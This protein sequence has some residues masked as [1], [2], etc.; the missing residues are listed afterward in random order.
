MWRK[1]ER[2]MDDRESRGKERT[3]KR[4]SERIEKERERE[5]CG[6]WRVVMRGGMVER[7]EGKRGQ[8]RGGA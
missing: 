6:V 4:R 2:G 8:R 3:E 1:R 7:V 5:R